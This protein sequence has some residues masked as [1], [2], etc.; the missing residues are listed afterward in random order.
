MIF[1]EIQFRN[2]FSYYG[3]RTFD[4]KGATADENIAI[5]SGRNG[6]GKTSFITG[7][8]LL[9]G[10]VTDD[11]RTSVLP[12]R[13]LQKNP[14]LLGEGTGIEWQGVFNRRARTEGQT[15]FG[16]RITWR[17]EEGQ[18]ETEREWRLQAKSCDE[19][20]FARILYS[21]KELLGKEAEDF[22]DERLPRDYQ[23]FFFFDGEQIQ[24]IAAANQPALREHTENLLRITPYETL[25]S[26]IGQVVNDWRRE[27][28]EEEQRLDEYRNLVRR[29][30]DLSLK[31]RRCQERQK[32]IDD[33]IRD[34]E[35]EINV[36]KRYLES[37][38]AYTYERDEARWEEDAR[39]TEKEIAELESQL[40]T[41]L[42]V[43]APLLF[44]PELVRCAAAELRKLT[45]NEVSGQIQLLDDLIEHLPSE[46]F[47][48]PP[49][50]NPKLT[51]NQRRFFHRRLRDA[52]RAKRPSTQDALESYFGI[53]PGT[54]EALLD[55]FEYYNHAESI[56]LHLAEM[57]TRRTELRSKLSSIQQRLDDLSRLSEEER[58]EYRQRSALN[59]ERIE[60]LGSRR[61][62]LRNLK[63]EEIGTSRDLEN[64]NRKLRIQERN[65][66]T[67]VRARRKIKLARNIQQLVLDFKDEQRKRRRT[68]LETAI[69]RNV[70]KLLTSHSQLER[71]VI[72]DDFAMEYLDSN[73]KPIGMGNV[74]AGMRQLVATALLWSLKEVSGKAI[75]IVIDTPLARLD[76]QHQERMLKRYFPRVAE[77]VIVLPTNSELDTERYAWLKPHIYREYRLINRDGDN[78]EIAE[79]SMYP[80]G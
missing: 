17:E 47:D 80:E 36:E 69:N 13:K 2:L 3:I 76:R 78:T 66:D 64:T 70:H 4:L 52:L 35:R 72:N 15:V 40:A 60:Q 71:I 67:S 6:H 45:G 23:R 43:G 18:V 22:I 49:S 41:Q 51:E 44:N 5:L 42:P 33:Q 7:V 10:G 31:I 75:P 1:E 50:P 62:E 21:G 12:G 68:E 8:K 56:R 30:E 37:M 26:Y 24:R 73:G 48:R 25:H 46:V 11:L 28:A 61:E 20:I 65:L 39:R 16:V 57:L 63:N 32:D 54:A 55:I 27:A 79:E 77:Q 53:N 74:S 58:E 19:Q 59:E 29:V 38:R 14:F 9:F 34:L